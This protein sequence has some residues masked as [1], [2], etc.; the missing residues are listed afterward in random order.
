V[1]IFL[2][3]TAL[4]TLAFDLRNMLK[5]LHTCY[6]FDRAINDISFLTLGHCTKFV[7][8]GFGDVNVQNV[9]IFLR[10]I[11]IHEME[12]IQF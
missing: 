11:A 10:R 1:N 9:T 7:Q 2:D 3:L 4:T 6:I 12:N 8:A 5:T